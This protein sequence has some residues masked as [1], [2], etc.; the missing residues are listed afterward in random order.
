MGKTSL[1][2]TKY[3]VPL[4]QLD[5]G[6]IGRSLSGDGMYI[7]GISTSKIAEFGIHMPLF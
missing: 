3:C 6:D 5:E 2:L 7:H 4:H 1:A